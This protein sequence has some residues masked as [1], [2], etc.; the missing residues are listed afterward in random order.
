MAV[1]GHMLPFIDHQYPEIASTSHLA[2]DN[3]PRK[4]STYDEQPFHKSK[5]VFKFF[6]VA[7]LSV[8]ASLP[9]ANR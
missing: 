2:R 4:S 3:G 9:R 7:K 8:A 1:A 5:R 6:M